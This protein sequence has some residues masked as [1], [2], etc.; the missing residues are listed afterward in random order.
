[1]NK[2]RME[3]IISISLCIIGIILIVD[4]ILA[5]FFN[6]GAYA[7]N[8]AII[9]CS[10]FIIASMQYENIIYKKHVMIPLYLMIIQTFY[11][12]IIK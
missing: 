10:V 9:Y 6:R 3:L 5:Q 8:L 1:M 4:T 12:L 11:S 7:N 2:Q